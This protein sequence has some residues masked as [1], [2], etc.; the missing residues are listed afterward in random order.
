MD[1]QTALALKRAGFPQSDSDEELLCPCGITGCELDYDRKLEWVYAPTLE[2]LI[3]SCGEDNS[4][5]VGRNKERNGFSGWCAQSY[6]SRT[7]LMGK[8]ATPTIAVARLWLALNT[9]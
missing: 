1:Y 9:N 5:L 4:F 7:R 6:N 3:E 8:G 2:E